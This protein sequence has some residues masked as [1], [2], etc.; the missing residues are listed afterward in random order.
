MRALVVIEAGELVELEDAA[1]LRVDAVDALELVVELVG[2]QLSAAS[3]EAL[4]FAASGGVEGHERGLLPADAKA[5]AGGE[6]GFEFPQLGDEEV[7]VGFGGEFA[8]EAESD[9]FDR[10]RLLAVRCRLELFGF[11]SSRTS[12]FTR[13]NSV[14][15]AY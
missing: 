6:T 4:E 13:S 11:A 8:R 15:M 10:L 3:D 5:R 9:F 7:G 12:A 1:F 14:L 2:E